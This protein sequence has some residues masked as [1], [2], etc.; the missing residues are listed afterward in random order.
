V[1]DNQIGPQASKAIATLLAHN[2]N[3][4]HLDLQDNNLGDQGCI[5]IANA[6]KGNTGLQRLYLMSN[7]RARLCFF[8]HSFAEFQD[9]TIFSD[10]AHA[11]LDV[12]ET[13]HVLDHVG[14]SD[15]PI[16]RLKR[17]I[18]KRALANAKRKPGYNR[19]RYRKETAIP[20]FHHHHLF[21]RMASAQ[22]SDSE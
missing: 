8:F 5:E 16:G 4:E 13:N 12:F 1:V 2:Q 18:L 15:N 9:N 3:I 7:Q 11:I 22:P 10:G 20:K 17:R 21:L 14:I 19:E 6:L